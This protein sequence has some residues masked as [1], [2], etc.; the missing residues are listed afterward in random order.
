VSM[1]K[2]IVSD[3]E[4]RFGPS[5]TWIDTDSRHSLAK[6]AGV[7]VHVPPDLAQKIQELQGQLPHDKVAFYNR[8]LG[9]FESFGLNRNGDGF[10][11]GE[12]MRKHAT[13]VSNAHYFKHHCFP[14]GTPVLMADRTR[15]PIDEVGVG[16][17]VVT[18]DG[19]RPVT[20]VMRRPYQG[21]G[22]RL[23]LRGEYEPLTATVD[24]P[25]LVYRRDQIHCR[26]KYNRLL[27]TAHWS[28]YRCQRDDIGEPEWAPISS[29]LPGD[30]LLLPRPEHGTETV[31]PAFAGLVGWVA[32]EGNLGGRGSIQF[33]FSSSNQ[34]DIDSVIKCLRD[35]GIVTITVTPRPQYGTVQISATNKELH[36]RLSSMISGALSEKRLS[37]KILS[38]DRDSLLSM[39]AAY[40]DGD[41]HV[42]GG[43]NSGQ[44]R[45]RSSSP[46]M[47]RILADVIRALGAPAT[48]QWD[49]PP[50][51]MTSPTNDR[52]YAHSGSGCVAVAAAFSAQLTRG[53]RKHVERETR[54][55]SDMLVGDSYLVR[56]ADVEDVE[57]DE[58]V[59]N[60]EV[61]G[62]H[63]YVAGEVVVHNCNKDPA[64]GRGRPVA[65]SFNDQTD[66]VDL[67]IVADRDKCE[68]Q[69]QALES[70]SRV[71]TSMGAKVAF[72]V[73][74][75]CDH[76]AKT[77]D[78][79]C[80]HVNKLAS[81]PYGM[82]QILPDGRVCGV[83]NPEPTFFDISDVIVGA[84]PES[85]TLLKVASGD[86][87]VPSAE[88]A[89]IMG[90]PKW[91][92][93]KDAAIIKRLPG[94][95]TGY[96]TP[97]R[98][99]FRGIEDT[100]RCDAD[101]PGPVI[102]RAVAAG[103]FDGLLRNSAAM[104]IVLKPREFSRAAKLGAF[105]P[106][107]EDEILASEP[108]PS[109]I[110]SGELD[111]EVVSVL[112]SFY[113]QRST[114]QPA[115]LNRMIGTQEKTASEARVEDE[116]VRARKMY[117]AYRASLNHHM[118][119]AGG[120]DGEL[121]AMK[122][123]GTSSRYFTKSSAAYVATAF[124]DRSRLSLAEKVLDQISKVANHQPGSVQDLGF[125]H[126]TG[127][128]A[129]DLGVEA[130]DLIAVQSLRRDNKTQ[131]SI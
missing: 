107:S 67:I 73:C 61:E 13:F 91:A 49:C 94:E 5:M 127:T 84:A 123:A 114:H 105:N 80:Q 124:L 103:G 38:W 102:D 72:D 4:T 128:V 14:A 51:E 69:I 131:S 112:T 113:D 90:L 35:N 83:M 33:T 21:H 11:R 129:D 54:L 15:R 98:V 79:Y 116:D 3:G 89:E 119:Q 62:P 26:H 74:T 8:A 68:E 28:L 76:R 44:L 110:L 16:D 77:R 82:S 109:R 71:P 88:L 120:V 130:L 66:M 92:E 104:G 42:A 99:M 6:V 63:H 55:F 46:D 122:C 96:V 45:I 29:V 57:L 47:L 30:Y 87:V 111:R 101:I 24:H 58:E 52:V 40:I 37:G 106:P 19:P 81:P 32:S 126:I 118:P 17:V 31:D 56:V 117:A 86:I 95:A 50:G 65:S 64:L 78:E 27:K 115:L 108:I 70:G 60:L 85:E 39:L 7:G 12:L 75:I 53:S 18:R 59:F 121:V 34:A 100:A 23:S 125:C 25:V 22:V 20:A 36:G 1:W 2:V 97:D 10:A 41:G 43:K 93:D 9:A 48:V